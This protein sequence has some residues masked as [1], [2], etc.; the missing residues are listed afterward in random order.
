MGGAETWFRKPQ[1]PSVSPSNSNPPYLTSATRPPSGHR[2]QVS[3]HTS[4]AAHHWAQHSL[5]PQSASPL[6][7]VSLCPPAPTRSSRSNKRLGSRC[8][9]CCQ[10]RDSD[11]SIRERT[12]EAGLVRD[13]RTRKEL[14][15]PY[16][17][18]KQDKV[19][20]VN[21]VGKTVRYRCR[22]RRTGRHLCVL[23]SCHRGC[24]GTRLRDS[25]NVQLRERKIVIR[26]NKASLHV[27]RGEKQSKSPYR[28]D[29]DI[30]F[31]RTAVSM[32]RN[33]IVAR[34]GFDVAEM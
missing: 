10:C 30:V 9:R 1:P 19:D 27:F 29:P 12:S 20:K 8:I 2:M 21:A 31:D 17:V 3:V 32:V 22:Q 14:P 13:S 25:L 26:D 4:W 11:V 16:T 7:H 33:L 28:H 5:S 15:S 34:L 18:W 6:P 23:E 24:R